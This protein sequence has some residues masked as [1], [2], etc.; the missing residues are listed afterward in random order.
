MP[1]TTAIQTAQR[2]VEETQ[3]TVAG[4]E[5]CTSWWFRDE[6]ACNAQKRA[7]ADLHRHLEAARERA[8][9]WSADSPT[10]EADSDFILQRLELIV[11]SAHYHSQLARSISWPEFRRQVATDVGQRI[12]AAT[13]AVATAAGQGVSG[14]FANLSV[15]GWVAVGVAAL[16]ILGLPQPQRIRLRS[17]RFG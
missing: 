5:I 10:A 1:F 13:S 2:I 11:S 8:A 4:S 12:A 17:G 6:S 15:G 16:A 14:F 9:A 7:V 3:R